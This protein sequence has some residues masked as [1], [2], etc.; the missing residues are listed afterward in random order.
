MED[1]NEERL[2]WGQKV[3]HGKLHEGEEKPQGL[4]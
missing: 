3:L 1:C 4:D 2:L